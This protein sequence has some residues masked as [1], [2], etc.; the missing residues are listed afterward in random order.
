[1]NNSMPTILKFF[2]FLIL[3]GPLP[4]FYKRYSLNGSIEYLVWML[5]LGGI[6]LL[7]IYSLFSKIRKNKDR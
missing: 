4:A 5:T 2:G 6:V 3:L 7:I 1:M